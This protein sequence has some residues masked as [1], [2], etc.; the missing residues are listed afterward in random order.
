MILCFLLGLSMGRMPLLKPLIC[1]MPTAGNGGGGGGAAGGGIGGHSAPGTGEPAGGGG[2][3]GAPGRSFGGPGALANGTGSPAGGAGG[4]GDGDVPGL[5]GGGPDGEPANGHGKEVMG[6]TAED[7]DLGGPGKGA[8]Q[9]V[10]PDDSASGQAGKG[11]PQLEG[12]LLRLAAGKSL[13]GA[14][15]DDEPPAMPVPQ[16]KSYSARDFS[17]DKTNLPRYPDAV[18]AVVSSI[19]YGPDG[20]TD[21]FSTGAGILTSNSFDTVVGWYR[22]HLPAG[23]HELTIG[24]M[25]RMSRQLSPENLGKL[26]GQATGGTESS[27]A[28]ADRDA[29]S[30]AADRLRISL[31]EPPAGSPNKTGVMI[32]QHGDQPVEALL[33]AKIA[34]PP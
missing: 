15:A 16:G 31:F 33:Q 29:A 27:G 17:Y 34:P 25:G 10:G 28:P 9:P 12:D 1:P 11:A 6:K 20:R 5:N 32:V 30:A 18:T 22:A 8:K 2:G 3:G 26:L 7:G 13:S 19:S 21:R 24:D 4:G 23:W 14:G